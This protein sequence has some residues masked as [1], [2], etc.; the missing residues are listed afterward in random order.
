MAVEVLPK[1][2]V[3]AFDD[4]K[5]E[6]FVA[7]VPEAEVDATI[8]NVA[9]HNRPYVPKEA[10]GAVAEKGDKVTID[11]VG[12]VDGEPFEGGTAENVDLV[13]GS[14]SFIPG[15]ED[16]IEGMKLGESRTISVTF[17]ETYAQA[18]LAG[19]SAKFAVTLKAVAAPAELAIDDDFAKGL[20][21][22]DLAK[23]RELARAAMERDQAAIARRKWK[24]ELLDALD[25]KYT[26]ELPDELVTR[27]FDAIWRQAEA[28]RKASGEAEGNEEEERSDYRKIAERRVRLGLVLA[29]IGDWRG[30]KSRM[31]RSP[32]RFICAPAII[33]AWKS[34]LSTITARIPSS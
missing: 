8:K 6:R 31:R 33:P 26:F 32:R 19:K 24:R 27:E 29:E 21:F 3:G 4:I 2:E 17:P 14:G 1:V 20:G 34:N 28:E 5:I 22:D 23:L 15:F 25:Q 11:F 10:E 30:S 13:L 16:Q 9:D 18:N 7:D 12:T